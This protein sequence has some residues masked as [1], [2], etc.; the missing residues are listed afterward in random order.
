MDVLEEIGWGATCL[1]EDLEF[2]C[3]LILNGYRIGWAH[4]AVVFDE[5]PLTLAQSWRQ[6]RRWM[7][8]FSD[9]ATRY[10]GALMRRAISQR[11]LNAFDCAMYVL[12][13]FSVLILSTMV[14][15]TLLQTSATYAGIARLAESSLFTS[16]FTR[17]YATFQFLFTPL[18]MV[19]DKRMGKKMFAFLSLYSLNLAFLGWL[20][21]GDGKFYV[22]A[23]ANALSGD[24]LY[25]EPGLQIR[26]PNNI[27]AIINQYQLINTIR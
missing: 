24:S 25:I 16:V 1:T 18:V 3:R 23:S 4:D 10:T 20:F 21:S 15:V 12:Q 7:Q 22:I 27:S 6:R 14:G 26:I 5:K 13:P 9:V 8:G 11:D 2:S 17:L 19:L